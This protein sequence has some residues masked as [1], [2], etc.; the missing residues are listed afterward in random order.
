MLSQ[1]PQWPFAILALL[2]ALG[3]WQRRTREVTPAAPAAVAAAFLAFSIY[4][5]VSSFG[6]SPYP[7]V[8]WVV[9]LVLALTVGSPLFAPRGLMPTASRSRV[10]VPGS[11]TP[12]VL[13]LC[14]F[15]AKFLVGF[16]AGARLEVGRSAWFAPAIGLVLGASSGG[17]VVRA[18]VVLRFARRGSSNAKMARKPASAA[19]LQR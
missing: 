3:F 10:L 13:M 17:F 4:G 12:L 9:G 11:W 6:V 2:V 5:V 19:H 16:V 18:L 14:I 8:A 7:L 1:I 15:S